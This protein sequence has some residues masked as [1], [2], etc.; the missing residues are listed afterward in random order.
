MQTAVAFFSSPIFL[1]AVS[2]WFSAQFVKGLISLAR[3]RRNISKRDLAVTLVWSTGGMPSSH[4]AVVS[5]L[6]TALG[7]ETGVLSPVFLASLCFSLL[8][9]RDALGV[10]QAAGNQARA[11]NQI[12]AD[13]NERHQTNY[14]TVKEINGHKGPEVIVGALLGIFL[15]V[16]FCNL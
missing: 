3:T 2:A 7:F 8:A 1:A 14:K 9:I 5:A 6:T 4:A 16:A 13:L 10:R 15:A 11:L 12:I